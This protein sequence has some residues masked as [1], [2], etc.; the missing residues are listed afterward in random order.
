MNRPYS[1]LWLLLCSLASSLLVVGQARCQIGSSSTPSADAP[2]GAMYD[3]SGRYI[4]R[5]HANFDYSDLGYSDFDYNYYGHRDRGNKATTE[6]SDSHGAID[7]SKAVEADENGYYAY[8]YEYEHTESGK[9]DGSQAATGNESDEGRPEPYGA[10]GYGSYEFGGS[11]DFESDT[12]NDEASRS[13]EPRSVE[14][15]VDGSRPAGDQQDDSD[16]DDP[17]VDAGIDMAPDPADTATDPAGTATDPAGTATGPANSVTDPAE[18]GRNIGTHET[19]HSEFATEFDDEHLWILDAD[20]ALP[21]VDE[22]R[23]YLSGH[24]K[25]YDQAVYGVGPAVGIDAAEELEGPEDPAI[26]NELDLQNEVTA[27]EAPTVEQE[28]NLIEEFTDPED[29]SND[30]EFDP[31]AT[32]FNPKICP[33]RNTRPSPPA[34]TAD[35]VRSVD[36]SSQGYGAEWDRTPGGCLDGWDDG[37]ETW[38][39]RPAAAVCDQE[40]VP[41]A[42]IIS[43]AVPVWHSLGLVK[44]ATILLENANVNAFD[45]KPLLVPRLQSIVDPHGWVTGDCFANSLLESGTTGIADCCDVYCDQADDQVMLIEVAET[46]EGLGTVLTDMAYQLRQIAEKRRISLRVQDR[47]KLTR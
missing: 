1:A 23:L 3:T 11:D 8:D 5:D 25:V 6:A 45:V 10:Y 32:F 19:Y 18:E 20:P 35:D 37:C 14:P 31:A 28:V 15:E 12:P 43:Q 17:A 36:E 16:N 33:E 21:I 7:E 46:L 26:G 38:Y 29:S 24:D 41:V 30:S 47:D 4:A 13:V 34:T 2:Y 22:I 39:Q 44:L 9:T 42:A 27:P 40:L